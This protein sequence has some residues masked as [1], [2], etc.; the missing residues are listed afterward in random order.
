MNPEHVSQTPPEVGGDAQHIGEPVGQHTN[1]APPVV[2]AEIV[3]VERPRRDRS[4]PSP[5]ENREA[6]R[7]VRA[8]RRAEML[9]VLFQHQPGRVAEKKARAYAILDRVADPVEHERLRARL[10]HLLAVAESSPP[11]AEDV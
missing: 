9:A 3:R 7:Q 6:A 11:P 10:T 5:S 4:R 2:Q 8:A 1:A